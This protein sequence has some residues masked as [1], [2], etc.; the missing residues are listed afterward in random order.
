M[1]KVTPP[2]CLPQRTLPRSRTRKPRQGKRKIR[3]KSFEPDLGAEL[4]W[5]SAPGC[6]CKALPAV[7]L[8]PAACGEC[9][10]AACP[11]G[12]AAVGACPA[13]PAALQQSSRWA[14]AA[15]PGYAGHGGSAK[16]A[17]MG[18]GRR[19]G[20]PLTPAVTSTG[21]QVP[22]PSWGS[23]EARTGLYSRPLPAPDRDIHRGP[24]LWAL[25]HDKEA[26]RWGGDGTGEGKQRSEWHQG[27]NMSPLNSSHSAGSSVT[28]EQGL[29]QSP[30]TTPPLASVGSAGLVAAQNAL[31][32]DVPHKTDVP[33]IGRAHPGPSPPRR[34]H[35]S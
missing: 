27:S 32:A 31:S 14:R 24:L 26:D 11:A 30:R 23:P 9:P 7:C 16:C 13:A 5:G 29:T 33:C 6:S 12:P 17:H 2:P 15:P 22:P 21:G 4:S 1:A 20:S 25:C 28:S 3:S 18:S 10:S 8:L 35:S 34:G 19:G